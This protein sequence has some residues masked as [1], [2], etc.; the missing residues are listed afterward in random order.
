MILIRYDEIHLPILIDLTPWLT[1]HGLDV[2]DR[3]DA[4]WMVK[5]D[6]KAPDEA[7]L[8]RG[9][10]DNGGLIFG[11]AIASLYLLDFSQLSPGQSYRFG[12]GLKFPSDPRFR[13]VRLT[14]PT[15]QVEQDFLRG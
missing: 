8:Y 10:E 13:E 6:D 11:G 15:F 14:D 7:A 1:A 4:V 3:T 9:D 2:G 12:L 5:A